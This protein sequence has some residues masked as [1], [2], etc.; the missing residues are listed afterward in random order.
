M[1][2]LEQAGGLTIP[3]LLRRNAV[4]YGDLPALTSLDDN[5]PTNAWHGSNA[6][7]A[8]G[9]CHAAGRRSR[10]NSPRR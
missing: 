6:S 5:R 2:V 8:T 7:S 3:Q 10:A 1:S 9:C 4:D